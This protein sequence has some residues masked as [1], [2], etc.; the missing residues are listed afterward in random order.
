[1]R[2]IKACC[3]P[4][5]IKSWTWIFPSR[6]SWTKN[7]QDES[8]LSS[9]DSSCKFLRSRSL[10]LLS[11]PGSLIFLNP[12]CWFRKLP[13]ISNRNRFEKEGLQY[14]LQCIMEFF[15]WGDYTNWHTP[16]ADRRIRPFWR[17]TGSG[18]SVTAELVTMAQSWFRGLQVAMENTPLA[19]ENWVTIA[20]PSSGDCKWLSG[21]LRLSI[22]WVTM[23]SP[24]VRRLQIV[25]CYANGS[26]SYRLRW[27]HPDLGD[28]KPRADN[29][30]GFGNAVTMR[31]PGFWGL[32]VVLGEVWS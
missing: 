30:S 20:P 14:M 5:T 10:M 3:C 4:C 2:Q 12:G 31:S 9:D 19:V 21:G 17:S 23:A 1:M 27:H 6:S 22:A 32:P 11:V 15:G 18:H 25:D 13:P 8:S 7:L 26:I 24:R 16:I 29:L 28:C